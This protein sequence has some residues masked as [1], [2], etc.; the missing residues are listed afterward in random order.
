MALFSFGKKRKVSRKK[1]KK[2]PAALLKKCKKHGIKTTMK[3]GGKRVYR[4]ISVLKRLLARKIKSH[5]KKS[6]SHR[7]KSKSH[8]K[9]PRRCWSMGR[10][11]RFGEVAG[12]SFENPLNYGYNQPDKQYPQTL[13][14][15]ST[16]VNEQMN[17]SRVEG[18]TLE[19]SQV[20]TYGVFREFFGQD[21]PTQVPPNWNFMGQPDGSLFAVGSPMQRYTKPINSFGKKNKKTRASACVKLSESRCGSNPNCNYTK[22][23]CRQRKGTL[24]GNVVYQGPQLAFG[25][26]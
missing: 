21:V 17:N 25:R 24:S 18:L 11:S 6:K 7:K 13:S 22:N 19:K 5:R 12:Y 10:R 23:G 16:V 26:Y 4:K 20:P 3:K 8:R 2:P 14:Q 1:G 15:S 9:K